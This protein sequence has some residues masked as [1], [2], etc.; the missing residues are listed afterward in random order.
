MKA[1]PEKDIPFRWTYIVLPAAILLA[2]IVLAVFFYARLP[3]QLAYHFSGGAPDRWLGRAAFLA[4]TLVPQ[5]ALAL[6]AFA[7]VGAVIFGARRWS[8]ESPLL[9]KLLPAMGNLPALPQLIVLFT[10]LDV[11]LYNSY[12]IK[13]ISV[14]ALAL[15][16]MVLG[17]IALGVLLAR[18]AGQARRLYGNSRRE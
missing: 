9:Q 11:F 18:S 10:M 8:F 7:L 16:V 1:K 4:W 17:G 5:A 15:A 3:E 12:Q 6:L 14:W 2:S 13:L